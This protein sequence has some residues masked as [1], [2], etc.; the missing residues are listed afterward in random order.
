MAVIG[1]VSPS[2]EQGPWEQAL[3]DFRITMSHRTQD[4]PPAGDPRQRPAKMDLADFHSVSAELERLN[5]AMAVSPTQGV[6][7]SSK[8]IPVDAWDGAILRDLAS[9][10]QATLRQAHHFFEAKNYLAALQVLQRLQSTPH[11]NED[12]VS[13]LNNICVCHYKMEDW[14]R[15]ERLAQQIIEVCPACDVA[16]R[17]LVRSLVATNDLLKAKAAC[18][19]VRTS[20]RWEREIKVVSCYEAYAALYDVHQFALAQ[21]SLEAAIGLFPCGTLEAL[22]VQLLSLDGKGFALQYAQ[23]RMEEYPHSEDLKYW[24]YAISFQYAGSG[25]ALCQVLKEIDDCSTFRH[26]A[27]LRQLST[28]VKHCVEVINRADALRR[29]AH[30]EDMLRFCRE[31]GRSPYLGEGTKALLL[32]SCALAYYHTNQIYDALDDAQRAANYSE[33]PAL[34]AEI[35]T[36]M[37]RCE[38]TLG[39]LHDAIHHIRESIWCESS[40][41]QTN[42]LRELE[43]RQAESRARRTQQTEQARAPPP[44]GRP[45]ASTSSPKPQTDSKSPVPRSAAESLYAVFSLQPGAEMLSVKKAYR[46]LAMKWHPDKW[47][48]R[49]PEEIAAA[50]AHFKRIQSAYE[51]LLSL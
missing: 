11:V 29:A 31:E 6:E 39:R 28:R 38:A 13:L 30:W 23:L 51:S 1:A 10:P 24:G 3:E 8:E 44:E 49:S 19:P 7:E 15:C 40:D 47:C 4:S 21:Q 45:Q 34:R 37:A 50:E 27:R 17:R 9:V 16:H 46:A 26:N 14:E 43:R 35:Y 32:F 2:Q 33:T 18:K 41:E 22:K 25:A 36:L 48:G 42:F 20:K 12:T 5:E